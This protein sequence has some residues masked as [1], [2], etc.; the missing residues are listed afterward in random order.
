M[1]GMVFNRDFGLLTVKMQE[2]LIV[3]MRSIA[4]ALERRAGS[5]LQCAR[6]CGEIE[7]EMGGGDRVSTSALK[8]RAVTLLALLIIGGIIDDGAC[9]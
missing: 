5:W 6:C 1:A 2:A 9:L 7:H 8:A 4:M 3:A